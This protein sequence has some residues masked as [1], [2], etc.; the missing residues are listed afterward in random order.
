MSTRL[1][2]NSL[3]CVFWGFVALYI[4][5]V[6]WLPVF[7]STDGPVHLYYAD[8]TKQLIS[9]Q[10][11]YGGFFFIRH[12]LPPYSL[13][14]YILAGLTAVVSS[15]LAEKMLICVYI[16]GFCFGVRFLAKA[17][18]Q[19][20]RVASLAALP[21]VLHKLVYL[22]FY[23]FDLSVAVMLW[24]VGFWLWHH[25]NLAGWRSIGFVALTVLL[26]VTHPVPLGVALLFLALHVSFSV[27]AES[28]RAADKGWARW[29]TA[30]RSHRR[31]MLHAG[32][33]CLS[34][35]YVLRYADRGISAWPDWLTVVE[36]LKGG[37]GLYVLSP[38][39]LRGYRIA[40][41][42]GI[43]VPLVVVAVHLW[44]RRRRF[45]VEA[46]DAVLALALLCASLYPLAP[47][48]VGGGGYLDERFPVLGAAF[49][50][51]FL[52]REG[53]RS[54]QQAGAGCFL[55]AVA[56]V[57]LFQQANHCGAAARRIE[58]LERVGV[59]PAGSTGALLAERRETRL[60]PLN[61]DPS[62]WAGAHYF[63]RSRAVLANGPW[64]DLP[65]MILNTHTPPLSDEEQ[66]PY[67]LASVLAGTP[68]CMPPGI[69][70]KLDF[71]LVTDWTGTQ[72]KRPLVERL[73][74]SCGFEAVP[75]GNSAFFLYSSPRRK[76]A[77]GALPAETSLGNGRSNFGLDH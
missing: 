35:C 55:A 13:H 40:L 37:L 5:Y 72:G 44:E 25:D 65:F 69:P 7:P 56:C 77:T 26:M 19:G 12:F 27:W 32:V 20:W 51:A 73:A 53:L 50:A 22:G 68:N 28:R 74:A 70:G 39:A 67:T 4:V 66:H 29:R 10:H 43:V 64:M 48:G 3:S 21:I 6:L 75:W 18:G 1:L 23:N 59:M 76:I 36:R 30:L 52:G 15:V 49:L 57:V 11:A 58:L 17:L 63:R 34:L 54:W 46:N 9:D 47:G 33:V 8:V 61:F 60:S 31:Q 38:L 45:A 2:R 24:F 71:F 14:T 41:G 62:F 42:V 16:C